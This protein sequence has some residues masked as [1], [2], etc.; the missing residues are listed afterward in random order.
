MKKL[1]SDEVP[2]NDQ[3]SGRSAFE[4][5]NRY[6]RQVHSHR[7]FFGTVLSSDCRTTQPASGM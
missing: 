3:N 6:C 5:S 2:S 7:L 1:G 4:S